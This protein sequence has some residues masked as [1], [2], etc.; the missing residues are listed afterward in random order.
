VIDQALVTVPTREDP[1]PLRDDLSDGTDLAQCFL[2]RLERR[3]V[4]AV[5]GED[6]DLPGARRLD[7]AVGA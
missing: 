3:E 7:A 5:G 2:H 1:D 6:R 4:D